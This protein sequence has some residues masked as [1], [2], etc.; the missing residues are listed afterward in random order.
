M[1]P[2][3]G[4][5]TID[6]SILRAVY[7]FEAPKE[8]LTQAKVEESFKLWGPK[9]AGFHLFYLSGGGKA[10]CVT[11]EGPEAVCMRDGAW[12][13]MDATLLVPDD[14]VLPRCRCGNTCR[15]SI[16]T[17]ILINQTM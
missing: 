7:D 11:S 2:V 10:V 16:A 1:V 15:S 8:G 14:R 6:I 4:L 5:A 17:F 13:H 12:R 9:S 3:P